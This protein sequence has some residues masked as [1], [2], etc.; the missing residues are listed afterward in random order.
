MFEKLHTKLHTKAH[1][2]GSLRSASFAK[3]EF[4]MTEYV[5]RVKGV[6]PFKTASNLNFTY[7]VTYS[8]D[9]EKSPIFGSFSTS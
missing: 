2:R 1:S 8:R 6:E 4:K 9:H 7:L 5:E 3:F